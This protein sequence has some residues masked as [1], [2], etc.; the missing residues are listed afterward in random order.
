M[1]SILSERATAAYNRGRYRE[2]LEILDHRASVAP[3]QVDL[4]VLRGYSL[5]NLRRYHLAE[6]V[7]EAAAR[8]GNAEAA[9]G[10]KLTRAAKR[11][12]R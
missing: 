8:S 3:E 9:R 10:L 6:K 4:M 1:S 12:P 5:Y 2:T 7:F 11:N